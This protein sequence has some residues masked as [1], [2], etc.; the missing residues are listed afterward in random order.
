VSTNALSDTGVEYIETVTGET[1]APEEQASLLSVDEREQLLCELE[2]LLFVTGEPLP[3]PRLAGLTG[4]TLAD[5]TECLS[6]LEER[7]SDRGLTIRT[8]GG[9]YRFATAARTRAAVESLLL[10]PKTSLS[11]AALETLAVVAYSQPVTKAEIEA[12][13]GVSVDG[14]VTSLVEKGFLAEAG[15]KELEGTAE[16]GIASPEIAVEIVETAESHDILEAD[17]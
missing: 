17:S 4:K 2:A 8:V 10:P 12:V 14:I 16:S 9:G 6:E 13:R 3:I 1:P 15:R 7:Y 11:P 5:V